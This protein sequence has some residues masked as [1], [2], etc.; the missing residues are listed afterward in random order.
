M[1][2]G[3]TIAHIGY[4]GKVPGRGD[5]VKGGDS[6]A[7][8]KVLDDWL[9]QAMDLMSTDARWKL[10]YDAVAPLH[11][12]FVGPRRRHAIAGH[13]VASSDQSSRRFPFLMTS[14]VEVADPATF[15]QTAPLVFNRLWTRLAT[16]SSGVVAA[17]DPAT[18][19]Q[20][21]AAEAIELD[22]RS[23]AYQA[24]FEDFLELQT[25]GGLDTLLSQAGFRGSSRQVLLALGMLLQ[26]VMASS[27]SRLDK[28]LLLPLPQD[29]MYRNLVAAFWLHLITP[30]LARADFELA[31]FLTRQREQPVLLVGFSG[32]SPATLHGI[33]DPQAAQ[34][35]QIAFEQLD[36]VEEQADSDYAVKK[37]STYLSQPSLSLKSALES[38][39]TAFIGT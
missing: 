36:W 30:F 8:I 18:P 29:P 21:A 22:L 19:L 23:A 27:S 11:F 26:P 9:A 14:S 32:A 39:S 25:I 1:S 24:T 12:A 6:P 34:E 16:L 28:T 33:M 4:F 3:A 31:L 20:M 17:S 15:V 13:I 35:Q 2:R 37:L 10:N 38:V 7:L 5:F